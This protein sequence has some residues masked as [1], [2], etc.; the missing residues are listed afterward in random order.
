NDQFGLKTGVLEKTTQKCLFPIRFLVSRR[1]HDVLARFL[2]HRIAACQSFKTT[3]HA[4]TNAS[5]RLKKQHADADTSA[6]APADGE[7]AGGNTSVDAGPGDD[8][9]QPHRR[10]L[11]LLGAQHEAE[12]PEVLGLRQGVRHD[13][14]HLRGQA[15][16]PR[17]EA[18][19]RPFGMR[20]ALRQPSRGTFCFKRAGAG[21]GKRACSSYCE[22]LCSMAITASDCAHH[23]VRASLGRPSVHSRSGKEDAFRAAG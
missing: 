7:A 4:P 9:A 23:G 1:Q 22:I 19:A 8:A 14:G 3:C 17:R 20:A 13:P 18:R 16:C 12:V 21:R 5:S 6:D 15:Q 11:P 2:L 10:A